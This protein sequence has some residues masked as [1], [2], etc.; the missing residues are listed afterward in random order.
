MSELSVL[1][2]PSGVN[3][4]AR[5]PARKA[6]RKPRLG[7]RR[8]AM[9]AARRLPNWSSTSTWNGAR[10]A[11]AAALRG[12]VR[13]TSRATSPWR[14]VRVKLR[15]M[16][17]GPVPVL[18]SMTR[19]AKWKVPGMRGMPLS[20]PVCGFN[21]M[22]GRPGGPAPRP[23]RVLL[24]EDNP[25]NQKLAVTLLERQGHTVAVAGAGAA[26]L[27]ALQRQPFDLV[28]MDVQMP[29]M[30]GLETTAHIR[31]REAATGAHVPIV[32][33]TA[34]A[35]KGDRERCLA[36][37]MDDY[38]SKPVRAQ[39]L[40]DAISRAVGV[41]TAAVVAGDEGRPPARPIDWTSARK[42]AGEDEQL[43]REL[44]RLFL[45]EHPRWL[46]DVRQALASADAAALEGAAH[47][48]RGALGTLGAWA[49]FD[50]ALRVETLGR[51]GSLADAEGAC[52]LLEKEL[53]RLRAELTA[54]VREA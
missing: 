4:A 5:R 52:A 54:F 34:Y 41:G 6:E 24:A 15:V 32:A 19:T 29:G 42:H 53:E 33:M 23:L 39:E 22:P 44:A 11:P 3:G 1:D 51:K 28:L 27:D 2:R 40:Y 21:V 14:T 50:E 36:A 31:R 26:V 43:L 47:R 30:D 35:M 20:D 37:G 38:V 18:A 16:L 17:N 13:N 7:A 9:R 25:V 12:W 10:K 45:T 49:A 8:S 48:L 46:A